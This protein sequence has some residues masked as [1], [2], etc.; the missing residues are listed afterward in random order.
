[1]ST[2]PVTDTHP[3]EEWR[4]DGW[5]P[6]TPLDDTV[7]RRT[8]HALAT[9][10]AEPAVTMGARLLR[11]EEIVGTDL[12]RPAAYWNAATVLRPLDPQA[13]ASVLD[14]LETF[15]AGAEGATPRPYDLWS[16]FPTPDL[17]V[18]GWRLSGHVPL[19]WRPPVAATPARPAG[20]RVE[21]VRDAAGLRD[22][23]TTAV[24]AFPLDGAP[25]TVATDAFLDHPGL[26]LFVGY[27]GDRPV[28]VSSTLV[29]HGVN[30]VPLVAVRPEVRGLGYGETVTWAATLVRPELPA[31]LLASDAGRPVYERMGY[32]PLVRWPMWIL[33]VT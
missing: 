3:A 19:M 7:L 32:L 25:D 8:V 33:D 6:T 21:R 16:P 29:T 23:A 17:R 26:R 12:G 13:W 18:R 20:L 4:E 14:R 2:A 22:W 30:T 9:A 5:S 1:M 24:E 31:A 11:T 15:V 28:A 27:A 10:T